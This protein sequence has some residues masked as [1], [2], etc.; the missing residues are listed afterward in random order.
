MVPSGHQTHQMIVA[1]TKT[2]LG[3]MKSL[4]PDVVSVLQKTHLW[5]QEKDNLDNLKNETTLLMKKIKSL[6]I[7]QKAQAGKTAEEL[8]LGWNDFPS[9]TEE[10][11]KVEGTIS[12]NSKAWV[13]APYHL[14]TKGVPRQPSIHEGKQ[15][16]NYH[17]PNKKSR[18]EVSHNFSDSDSSYSEVSYSTCQSQRQEAKQNQAA[19]HTPT[20]IVVAC[21]PAKGLLFS[22][23]RTHPLVA[24][25]GRSTTMAS[26]TTTTDQSFLTITMGDHLSLHLEQ[27]SRELEELQLN[28]QSVTQDFVQYQAS[29]NSMANKL[30]ALHITVKEVAQE[31]PAT[32]LQLNSFSVPPASAQHTVPKATLQESHA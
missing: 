21:N 1:S 24:S 2:H 19:A 7:T 11:E 32:T 5:V 3:L 23:T 12:D 6:H 8:F 15:S 17:H 27:Q 20:A 13:L 31:M 25:P 9:L 16:K 28:L 22:H 26:L 10:T 14:H 18:D 4:Q 29:Q 30:H